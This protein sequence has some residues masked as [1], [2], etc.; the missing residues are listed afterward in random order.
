METT[1]SRKPSSFMQ[2]SK[3]THCPK[4]HKPVL[5]GGQFWGF[6]QFTIK[7]PWCQTVIAV[8]VQ[9]QIQAKLKTP[10]PTPVYSHTADFNGLSGS[11]GLDFEAAMPGAQPDSSGE[12]GFKVVGYI[13]PQGEKKSPG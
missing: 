10:E 9:Q 6:A 11:D 4:C 3:M 7:C 1:P 8:T 13:Y 5:N 2:E 12:D